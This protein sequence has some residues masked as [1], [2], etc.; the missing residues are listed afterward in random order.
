MLFGSLLRNDQA[1]MGA[2]MKLR[3]RCKPLGC[4]KSTVTKLSKKLFS[5][6]S[7]VD[8][9]RLIH[10]R[11]GS[12]AIWSV[13]LVYIA[14]SANY[15][16]CYID[17]ALVL[18]DGVVGFK[19]D[20]AVP[21]LLATVLMSMIILRKLIAS[22]ILAIDALSGVVDEAPVAE[23]IE[24]IRRYVLLDNLS[25]R[26]HFSMI[27]VF[28]F[29]CF[30]VMQVFL[31]IF[32]VWLKTWAL[33]P[34]EHPLPFAT[35]IIGSFLVFVVCLSN[36]LWYIYVTLTRIFYFLHTNSVAGR[37]SI[38]PLYVNG[39]G[40]LSAIANLILFTV[41]LCGSGVI[42]VIAWVFV[43]GADVWSLIGTT[44]YTFSLVAVFVFPLKTIFSVLDCGK[45][46]LLHPIEYEYSFHMKEISV[47]VC[48]QRSSSTHS[49]SDDIIKSLVAVDAIHN[50]YAHI[51]SI[52]LK[53]IGLF[54]IS[55]SAFVSILPLS[56]W[57][58]N[59]LYSDD[60]R[61]FILGVMT[62]TVSR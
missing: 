3:T 30:S 13:I 15:A 23:S 54:S 39:D 6:F 33:L 17:D 19:D 53:S 35:A 50:I 34:A 60:I 31:P 48:A 45:A 41:S 58:I 16:A 12:S 55:K 56:I 42:F 25:G 18:S 9:V 59:L 22:V 36:A 38:N 26:R 62:W 24:Q 49:R 8:I 37:V 32:G 11:N 43:F 52:S 10:F 5:L 44:L 46:K 14:Y 47:L 20:Y 61:T 27:L 2:S 4:I 1:K 28:L 21:A 51:N 40:D 57:M 7:G 29:T